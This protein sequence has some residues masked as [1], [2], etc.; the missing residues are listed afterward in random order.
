[1]S[2]ITVVV[3]CPCCGASLKIDKQLGKI[4][5][6]EAKVSSRSKTLDLDQAGALLREQAARRE[7]IFAQSSEAVKTKSQLLERKFEEGLK[8]TKDQPITRPARDFDLD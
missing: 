7:A 4:V 5:H 1:M 2:D 8:K 6:H 3:E